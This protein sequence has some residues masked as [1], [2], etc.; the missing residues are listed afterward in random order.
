MNKKILVVEDQKELANYLKEF[1]LD[2]DYII[3]TAGD[4]VDALNKV[5]KFMPDLVLLDLGLPN[6]DGES[7]CLE[8][9]KHW[10]ELKIIILTARN[11][12]QNIVK[13]LNLGAD[14][15]ITKPFQ[16]EELLARIKA[17]LRS[18]SKKSPIKSIGDL[19]LNEETHEVKRNGKS[20]FL[21]ATE[22]KLLDFMMSNHGKVISRD[23]ILSKIW[24]MSPDVE[25]RSVDVYIG[26]LRKKIDKGYSGK[27]I[28]SVR[29]FG[30]ILKK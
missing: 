30:Y 12:T 18:D 5:S 6:M 28:H 1:L 24:L 13:G 27:L 22:F 7:V 17:R 2:N 11:D 21:T 20:V 29:G 15:Y 16:L 14:D 4:G 19:E 25:T 3:Q 26:Y 9:K 23:M 10:P 8:I